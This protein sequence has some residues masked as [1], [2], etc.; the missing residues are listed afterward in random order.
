MRFAPRRADHTRV[1]GGLKTRPITSAASFDASA[2]G[3]GHGQ[4]GVG[5]GLTIAA[6]AAKLLGAELM[7]ESEV[8][9]GSTFRLSLPALD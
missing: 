1:S 9:R 5:F 6:Q 8:G 7:V 2:R 3:E 4:H